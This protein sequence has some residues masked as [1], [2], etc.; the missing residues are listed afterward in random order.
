MHSSGHLLLT[1]GADFTSRGLMFKDEIYQFLGFS[2]H[3][4]NS[5]EIFLSYRFISVV[6]H[7]SSFHLAVVYIS[8]SVEHFL[9]LPKKKI[10]PMI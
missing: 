2:S 7:G 3:G 1:L 9:L 4:S 10:P 6:Q 5:Q 8:D